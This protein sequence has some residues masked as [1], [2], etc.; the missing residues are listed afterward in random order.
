[1]RK[2]FAITL[3]V[4]SSRANHTGAW[5]TERPAY[6][7]N[8]PPCNNACPAGENI[9]QWLY[10]AEE[11][12]AK[13]EAAWRQIMQ[14]N[15]FPAI[16]G[17]V[18]YRPCETACNRAQL[19][20]AVG[21]NSVERFLGDEAL[22]KGWQVPVDTASTGKRVLVA[23]A[24]PSGLSAAYHLA[25]MGHSVTIKDAGAAP[26]G[27]MRYGIPKYRLPRDILDAEIS[28]ILDMGITLELNAKVTDIQAE[29][30]TGYDAAFVAVGA[31]IGR[32]AYIPAGDSAR[33]MDAVSVLH[34]MEDGTPP[35]LG[36]RVAVYGGG[37]TAMDAARTAR[38]LGASEAVVVYR[39]T[40]EKM[41]AHDI[42]VTEALEEGV[43][44]RWLSTVAQAE[45]GKLV[46]EKMKLDETG[47]PQPTG[48]FEELEADC[49][50][51]ALG[52]NADLSV[53]DGVPGVTFSDG[54]VEVGPDLMTG[55]PGIFA[56]GDMVPS[57]RT[58]TVAIGHGKK[59]ARSID[60]FLRDAGSRTAG[61]HAPASFGA[62][63]IWYYA[64]AP[65]TV[66]PRLEAARRITTFDE[67][68]GGLDPSTALFEARRCMS[69]GN[70][71]GCDNCYG[72]CP[73]NA[74]I[75]LGDGSYEIDYDYCKGCGLCAAECPSGAIEME[76]E[77]S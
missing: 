61:K 45:A 24:G 68:T 57:E 7:H 28:R 48:E 22:R 54:V 38:R 25:R 43:T 20:S 64:D 15:P 6:V 46:I 2:P 36:R 10:D 40:R 70:C 77:P 16:M 29:L 74:I 5:R 65:A 34:S 72:V 23:G 58:V 18:C 60:A 67:V 53:L 66:R 26:G 19:D 52:Q 76:P 21:I 30:D 31:H 27:M 49:L 13:Y 11:G 42:E 59:A 63:N 73:D 71:F 62:L 51:L 47:F 35:M 41:P 55:H 17:R 39:R 44:M 1:M 9:Q 12:P 75:K 3:D 32:R 50:V 37:N 33:I 8:L 56:G 69:C 4:G 14:D